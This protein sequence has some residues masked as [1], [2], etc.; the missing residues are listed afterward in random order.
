MKKTVLIL[1]MLLAAASAFATQFEE[2]DK[3]PEGAHKGQILL[4]A[5]ANIGIPYGRI[6]D[7]EN[8][9]VRNSWYTFWSNLTTKKIM[10]QHL[11][12]SYGILFEYMP[13]DYLG[14]KVKVKRLT[15]VQRT[16]FGQ[17]Y[18]NWTKML[19]N[20]FSFF[21]G[22]SVHFTTRKQWDFSLTPV[23]GYAL[24]EYNAAPIAKL[25]VYK[26][27]QNVN[28]QILDIVW[29]YGRKSKKQV[30]NVVVGAE[31]SFFVYF[32]G[33]F[34]ISFGCDWTMNMLKFDGKFYQMNPQT[35][36]LFFPQS[37]FSY[38]HSVSFILSAGYAFSN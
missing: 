19:Y 2:L 10:V 9:Y 25:L 24:G 15:V 26:T 27:E 5:F 35:Y 4:G 13:V 33:G 34:F 31:L 11:T 38:L 14:I 37:D 17:Q 7:A 8:D 18:Q 22:P 12:F 29:G 1:M 16:M 32:T 21:I 20:D 36:R 28:L 3:P 30:Y 6:I 23:A